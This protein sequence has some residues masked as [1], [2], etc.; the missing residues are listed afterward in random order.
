MKSFSPLLLLALSACKTSVDGA[1]TPSAERQASLQR[2]R[3]GTGESGTTYVGMSMLATDEYGAV[4][5]CDEGQL[6]VTVSYAGATARSTRF[7]RE[8]S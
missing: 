3:G 4:I 2:L 7:R 8:A 1:P 5:A 6:D